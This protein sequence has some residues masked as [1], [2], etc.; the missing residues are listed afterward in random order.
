MKLLSLHC[1]VNIYSCFMAFLLDKCIFV[2]LNEEILAKSHSFM[3]GNE[4]LDE[5]FQYDA[6]LYRQQLLAKSYCFLL[7]DQAEISTIV[8]AFT[9]SNDSL[10]TDL[11]PNSR[12]K[13]VRKEIPRAKQMYRYPGVLIGRL[14]INSEFA[15]QGI[16][17][18]LLEFIKSWFVEEANKTGCRFITIDAYND[19]IPLAFY[20]KNGFEFLFSNDEQEAEYIRVTKGIIVDK[21]K[22][23]Q[24]YF[25][26]ITL[27]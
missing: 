15:H 25:D 18:E 22:T 12:E 23:K 13:K 14:A 3:C 19:E 16:G 4:D 9:L 27:L 17:S 7:D 21:L 20:Q 24:M 26:L 11:L 6:L 5:F 2:P 8:C 1:F 10:R